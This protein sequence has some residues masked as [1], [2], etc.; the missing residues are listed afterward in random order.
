MPRDLQMPYAIGAGVY[1]RPFDMADAQDLATWINDWRV[2]QT[3]QFRWPMS[4]HQEEDFLGTMYTSKTDMVLAICLKEE[5]RLIG[6]AG[7]HQIDPIHRRAV[8]GIF[9]G[10]VDEW[11]KGHATDASRLMIQVA[12]ERLNLRRIELDVHSFNPAAKRVYEK[13]GFEV[14]GVRRQHT[15]HQGRYHDTYLMALLRP[16]AV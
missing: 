3:L 15:H 16:E 4:V 11:G 12:F 6:G 13:L 9:I 8:F 10:D 7:L 14:E 1:L 2:A 5:N